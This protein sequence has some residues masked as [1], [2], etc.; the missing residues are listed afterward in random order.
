MMPLTT[1]LLALAPSPARADSIAVGGG[2]ETMR[3]SGSHPAANAVN[4]PLDVVPAVFFEGGGCMGAEW[5]LTLQTDDSELASVSVVVVTGIG[6]LDPGGPLEPDTLYHLSMVANDGSSDIST[7]SFTTGTDDHRE[8]GITPEILGLELFSAEGLGKVDVVTTTRFGEVP[9][10][11]LAVRWSSGD[12][13]S[14]LNE[15]RYGNAPAGTT[16]ERSWRSDSEVEGPPTWC[17][18]AAVREFAGDW[19]EGEPVCADVTLVSLTTTNGLCGCDSSG[20]GGTAA[21]LIGALVLA[22]RRAR[23]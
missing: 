23:R 12:S 6:E 22:H 10:E 7:I 20:P 8:T 4:V 11:D 17:A 21:L 3:P 15:D 16:V 13:R 18:A 1:L 2:C 14:A 5:T 19:S 9:G